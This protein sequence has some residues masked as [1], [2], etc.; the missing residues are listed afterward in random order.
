M[1]NKLY[2]IPI[3]IVLLFKTLSIVT[4]LPTMSDIDKQLQNAY[5]VIQYWCDK[6]KELDNYREGW[7]VHMSTK[8]PRDPKDQRPYCHCPDKGRCTDKRICNSCVTF[9]FNQGIGKQAI[10]ELELEERQALLKAEAARLTLSNN[11][12]I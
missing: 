8:D 6:R 7:Y 9:V 1:K 12:S 4:N 11:Q 10:Q 5:N 3:I 2:I